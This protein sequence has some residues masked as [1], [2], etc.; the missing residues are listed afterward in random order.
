MDRTT[1]HAQ[2]SLSHASAEPAYARQPIASNTPARNW[3]ERRQ[4]ARVIAEAYERRKP[5]P[6][7]DGPCFGLT[8]H[9]RDELADRL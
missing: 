5:V 8:D 4:K 3:R 6:R 9:V 2:R 1:T 7:G